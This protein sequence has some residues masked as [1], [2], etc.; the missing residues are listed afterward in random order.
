M[1]YNVLIY[2][3]YP[4]V[5]VALSMFVKKNYVNSNVA[6]VSLTNQ[7]FKKE[8][9]KNFDL[10]IIDTLNESEL[11]MILSKSS[12]FKKELKVIFFTD[13]YTE[14]KKN[15][16]FQDFIYLNKDSSEDKIINCLNIIFNKKN[17]EEN[18]IVTNTIKNNNALSKRE[19][20]CAI[21][22]MKGYSLN[23]ISKKLSLA[24]T[25]V[26]TYKMRILKKT[27]KNNLVELIKSLYKLEKL[28]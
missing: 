2:S 1:S 18:D 26:S 16:N 22:L 17:D 24:L 3:S 20:E 15:K 14:F 5:R 21:L 13:G 6:F 28:H 11:E 9:K 25:T 19:I 10:L 27:K 8:L 4:I 23:E 7:L 12:L